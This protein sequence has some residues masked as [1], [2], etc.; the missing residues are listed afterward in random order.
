[1]LVAIAPIDLPQ[2]SPA[3]RTAMIL[4]VGSGLYR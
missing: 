4:A 1:V 2:G 3:R